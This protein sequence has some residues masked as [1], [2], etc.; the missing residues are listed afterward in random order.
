MLKPQKIAL[1]EN[2]NG[3]TLIE[4]L[5][6]VTIIGILAATAVAGYSQ[7]KKRAYDAEAV[8]ALRDLVTAEEGYYVN[9]ESYTNSTA[10]LPALTAD[11][12][13][14]IVFSITANSRNFSASTYHQKGRKT[15]CYT[16]LSTFNPHNY[17]FDM[18]GL[19]VVCTGSGTFATSGT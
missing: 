14:N 6:S 10:L 1:I 2:Q 17:I 13:P 15:F 16:N 12:K 4:L 19:G 8:S 3:F 11:S 5:V 7:Y 18:I 9:E